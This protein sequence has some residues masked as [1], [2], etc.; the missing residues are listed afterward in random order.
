[1]RYKPPLSVSSKH[2]K[3]DSDIFSKGGVHKLLFSFFVLLFGAVLGIGG[4]WVA[5][6]PINPGTAK[7]DPAKIE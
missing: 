6:R 3:L 7:E 2:A 5:G 1:M 4:L